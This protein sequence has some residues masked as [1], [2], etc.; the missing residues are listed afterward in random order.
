VKRFAL[1]H[2]HAHS[3]SHSPF[4]DRVNVVRRVGAMRK[5]RWS[6]S[7]LLAN[8]NSPL[9]LIFLYDH[10]VLILLPNKQRWIHSDLARL[11]ESHFEVFW[12]ILNDHIKQRG[13]IR[14]ITLGQQ[15]DYCCIVHCNSYCNR[16]AVLL[17]LQLLL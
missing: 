3:H 11:Q 5:E 12:Y 14:K 2:S 8:F 4:R 15:L 9:L 1:T 10:T 7:S 13:K 6:C 17:S 16:R